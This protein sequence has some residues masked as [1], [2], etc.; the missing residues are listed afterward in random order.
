MNVNSL[1]QSHSLGLFGKARLVFDAQDLNIE[2]DTKLAATVQ[3]AIQCYRLI[4]DE[5]EKKKL[6]PRHHSIMFFFLRGSVQF[7]YSVMSYSLQP[8]GLQRARLLCP[9]LTPG[10]CSNSCPSSRWCHPTISSSAVPFSSRPQ[11]FPV[12]ESCPQ[13]PFFASDGQSI[14]VLALASVLALNIQ[15]WFPLGLVGSLCCP[16]DSQDS[17]PTPQYKSINSL[18][19]SFL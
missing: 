12:S 11:S 13:S 16:R 4:Y 10:P 7:S 8:H 9:S 2:Q 3:N 14:R 1:V 6:L 18:V 19:L 15:D 17:S 5:G